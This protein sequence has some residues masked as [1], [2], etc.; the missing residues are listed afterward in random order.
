RTFS[1]PSAYAIFRPPGPKV[2]WSSLLLGTFKIPQH[3]FILWLAILGKLFTLD[4]PWLRHLGS[5]CVLCTV[6]A[7]ESHEYL[8]F[9]CQFALACLCEI[10]RM[11]W[12]QWPYTSWSTA[13]LWASKRWRGKHIVNAAY[14]ALLAALVYHLWQERDFQI[15]QSTTRSP[16]NIAL[17]TVREVRELIVSKELPPN[18]STRGFY[19]IWDPLACVG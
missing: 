13:V 9:R 3:R 15:F 4:K 19:R 16:Q 12:F 6:A 11:V 5:D 2:G 18:V 17:I 7:Q 14:M 10:R 1:P 8:F